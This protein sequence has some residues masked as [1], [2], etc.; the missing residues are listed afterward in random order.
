MKLS[1]HEDQLAEGEIVVHDTFGPAFS[2][3]GGGERAAQRPGG[4]M[5][6]ESNEVAEAF[7]VDV[8]NPILEA[9]TLRLRSR[10]TPSRA[11]VTL[12]PDANGVPAPTPLCTWNVTVSREDD[13]QVISLEP[14]DPVAL[15]E[16]GK[17]W[18]CL[19][20]LE[21]GARIGWVSGD[22]LLVPLEA[23]FAE[24]RHDSDWQPAVS[25]GG[26]GHAL[27]VTVRSEG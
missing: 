27:R 7:L 1:E 15:Q 26:P 8:S 9:I 5:R 2:V 13:G 10:S 16:D 3:D 18:V 17:Y 22:R 14:P 23:T 11:L 4:D 21:P 20:A 25:A 12:N 6:Q 24:R 19:A